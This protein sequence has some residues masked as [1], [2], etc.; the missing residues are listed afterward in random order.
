MQY[1]L[2]QLQRITKSDQEFINSERCIVY[3]MDAKVAI[4]Q[5]G[6]WKTL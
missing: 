1:F 4:D 6:Q 3:S 5:V 2:H